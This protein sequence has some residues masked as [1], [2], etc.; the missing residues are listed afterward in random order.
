[1]N[2]EE[3]MKPLITLALCLALVGC[4]KMQSEVSFEP[5]PV[6]EVIQKVEDHS[7]EWDP[8][9]YELRAHLL[10]FEM[11]SKDND[12]FGFNL[13]NNFFKAFQIK[14]K[15]NKGQMTFRMDLSK[16][17]DT[18]N[19]II[20]VMSMAEYTKKEVGFTI[21]FNQIQVGMNHESALPLTKLVERGLTNTLK[22]AK[23]RL[24][25]LPLEW[26]THVSEVNGTKVRIPVGLLAGVRKGD[27]FSIYNVQA[28][29]E[30]EPCKSHYF[31]EYK[32]SQEPVAVGTVTDIN[33]VTAFL[34]LSQIKED[35]KIGS[36]VEISKL[37]GLRSTLQKSVRIVGVTSEPITLENGTKINFLPYVTEMIKPVLSKEN[38]FIR[39]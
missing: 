25:E 36:R 39:Q 31:G 28:Q 18:E 16:P 10:A 12:F 32:T 34:E 3:S 6:E 4:N 20:N 27:E 19:E 37:I 22:E 23:T 8:A 7:C 13:L 9:D 17:Q 21:D 35:V 14:F 29:W 38:F 33:E 30:G 2:L 5:V 11:T 26:S 1:M 15:V 24:Q